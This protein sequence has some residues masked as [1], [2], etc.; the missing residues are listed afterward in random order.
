MISLLVAFAARAGRS[1]ELLDLEDQYD[2][3]AERVE[4]PAPAQAA[5]DALKGEF[6][7]A[8]LRIARSVRELCA[9][10]DNKKLK[11]KLE[12]VKAE[13]ALRWILHAISPTALQGKGQFAQARLVLKGVG[14]GKVRVAGGEGGGGGGD[15]E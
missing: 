1:Q 15:R 9:E 12:D 11:D 2:R 10:G 7:S 6:S 14:G 13:K 3:P 5:V 4:D 8:S